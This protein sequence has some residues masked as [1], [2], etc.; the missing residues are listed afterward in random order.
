A[1]AGRQSRAVRDADMIAVHHHAGRK[2][3][4]RWRWGRR[5]WERKAYG[6]DLGVSRDASAAQEG[7]LRLSDSRIL[8]AIET[9]DHEVAQPGIVRPSTGISPG[10][11]D[12]PI[13][14][15]EPGD[16]ADGLR[17][18]GSGGQR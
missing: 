12:G 9:L 2:G 1:P 10:E 7:R 13:L 11:S 16:L 17:H 8:G 14:L 4:R 6:H 5:R 15:D 18:A 3:R